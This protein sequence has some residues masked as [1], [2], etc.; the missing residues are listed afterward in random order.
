MCLGEIFFSLGSD[1]EQFPMVKIKLFESIL[2][3]QR[4]DII[5]EIDFD[6]FLELNIFGNEYIK[7]RFKL[8]INSF[9]SKDYT[10]SIKPT[11]VKYPLER[12]F[13]MSSQISDSLLVELIDFG[14]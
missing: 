6:L 2:L 9:I 3:E 8:I 4:F 1:F 13:D 12:G 7:T 14:S 10:E 11:M 5:V